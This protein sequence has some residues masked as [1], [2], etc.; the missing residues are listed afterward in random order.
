[1]ATKKL[2]VLPARLP[3][4]LEGLRA[5]AALLGASLDEMDLAKSGPHRL[6]GSCDPPE[7][8]VARHLASDGDEEVQAYGNLVDVRTFRPF[9]GLVRLGAD[10]TG[11]GLY[12]DPRSTTQAG[13]PPVVR[14][15]HD[16]A[17]TAELE[18]NGLCEYAARGILLRWALAHD[19]LSA[20]AVSAL[21][22]TE[23][24][25]AD[26]LDG[27]PPLEPVPTERIDR[28]ALSAAAKPS[29]KETAKPTPKPTPT[30]KPKPKPKPKPAAK[31]KSR[32]TAKPAGKPKSRS[33]AKPVGKPKSRSTAKPAGKPK[34][35]STAKP[36]GKPK[37][38]PAGKPKS[39]STAKP[40]GKPKSRSKSR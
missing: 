16:E 15:C 25:L 36:A 2:P 23:V 28:R 6:G 39:R 9:S 21:L 22:A 13:T 18:A 34:S 14:F 32:S 33:T 3:L 7:V 4:D 11:D 29:A 8:L 30:P 1:M 38:K 37:Q 5:L 19:A 31:P 17:L 12:L 27:A 35:R 26:E 24:R 40:A 20:P 10:F